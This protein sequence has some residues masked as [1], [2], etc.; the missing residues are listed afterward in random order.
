MSE[1]RTGEAKA[2]KF[3]KT[4]TLNLDDQDF[5]RALAE[6]TGSVSPVELVNL[7]LGTLEW[8]VQSQKEGK[9]IYAIGG[10]A[11]PVDAGAQELIVELA[12]SDYKSD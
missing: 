5:L 9:K 4:I 10:G 1:K 2:K 7:A 3:P 12:K 6:T 11:E 8:V